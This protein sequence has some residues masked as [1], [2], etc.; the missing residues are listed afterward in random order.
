MAYNFETNST[1]SFDIYPRAY[2]DTDFTNV[3][4]LGTVGYEMA[5]KYADI[6]SLHVQVYPTLP[7]N[8]PNDPKAFTYL[9]IKTTTGSTTVI[10]TSWIKEDTIE[11]IVARTMV[12]T[13][14]NVSSSDI[15]RVRNA[16][17]QNGFNNLDIQ[18]VN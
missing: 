4:V 3:T 14:D 18:M 13:I 7:E 6:Y 10:A 15:N 2:F 16:L 5:A 1:Y 17:V 12:V 8:T 11:L 9:I